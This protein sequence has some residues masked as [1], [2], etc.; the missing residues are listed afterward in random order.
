MKTWI[1]DPIA[2]LAQGG[3]RGL[4]VDGGRIIELVGQGGPTTLCDE[5]FDRSC[6]PG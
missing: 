1:R 2:M 6:F 4:V 3:K 5:V